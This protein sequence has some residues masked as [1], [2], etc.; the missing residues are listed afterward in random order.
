M[1]WGEKRVKIED[2]CV[3]RRFSA[4][5]I[6]D[7]KTATTVAVVCTLA[8][9]NEVR[10]IVRDALYILLGSILLKP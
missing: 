9:C 3:K 5:L 2:F 1:E 4:P 6:E 8:R 7:D 10:A